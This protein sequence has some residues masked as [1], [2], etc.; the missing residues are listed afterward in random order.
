MPLD[1]KNGHHQMIL[2]HF[3]SIS[4]IVIFRLTKYPQVLSE[5]IGLFIL[6]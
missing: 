2:L 3:F 1:K 5:L 6:E 4:G